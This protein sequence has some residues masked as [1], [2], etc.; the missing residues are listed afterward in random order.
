[1]K[2]SLKN[3]LAEIGKAAERIEAFCEEHRAPEEVAY[4]I[5]LS[6]DELLTNAISYG[7]GDDAVHEIE[8][9]V[10]MDKGVIVVE[11]ID[12]A[13]PFDPFREAAIPDT[14]LDIGERPIGGL[15]VFLVRRMM[16]GFGYRR[17]GERN[18]VTIRKKAHSVG[19]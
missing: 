13:K 11:I 4:Q 5:N 15:G 10:T 6:V 1:M 19:G 17:E 16:D 12:N 3:D 9:D 8:I 18:I 7:Y 2:I 14:S